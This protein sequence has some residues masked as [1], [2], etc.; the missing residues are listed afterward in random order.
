MQNRLDEVKLVPGQPRVQFG[1]EYEFPSGVETNF[2]SS[3]SNQPYSLSSLL[4]YIQNWHLPHPDYA[5]LALRAHIS[6]VY[7]ADQEVRPPG[8]RYAVH[9]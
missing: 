6:T 4:F 2:V 7:T 5:K 8:Y 3:I 1:K 9:H